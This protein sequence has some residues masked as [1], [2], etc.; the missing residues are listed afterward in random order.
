MSTN[1]LVASLIMDLHGHGLL[2]TKAIP[3]TAYNKGASEMIEC[4]VSEPLVLFGMLLY[5]SRFQVLA[6]LHAWILGV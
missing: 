2:P 3:V 4:S 6:S 5:K 1:M